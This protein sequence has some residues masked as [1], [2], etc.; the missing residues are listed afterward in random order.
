LIIAAVTRCSSPTE[1]RSEDTIASSLEKWA[2]NNEYKISTP[3]AI[4]AV[5]NARQLGLLRGTNH[6]TAFGLAFAFLGRFVPSLLGPRS[7]FLT[8]VEDRLYLKVYLIGAGALVIKFAKWLLQRGPV[9]NDQL[10]AE[11][12]VERLMSEALDDYLTLATEI[13]DR[14]EIRHERE[15]LS[16]TEYVASTKRHKRYPLL[17]TMQRLH[18]LKQNDDGEDGAVIES[19]AGGR[20]AS[21]SRAL[22]DVKTLERLIRCDKLQETLDI[23]MREF[24]R[25]DLPRREKPM[26]VLVHAYTFAME[27]GMQACSLSFL[28]DVLGSVF[29]TSPSVR[30]PIAEQMLEPIHRE[31]PG[32]IRFHV[33][34]RG[35]RAFVLLSKT[36]IDHLIER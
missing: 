18:L 27:C 11:S 34:R 28:N 21:L 14:T 26:E 2:R 10:R 7:R 17:R 35:Q 5:G 22:P 20:L 31:Q 15:R 24:T 23:E 13:R 6:W 30:R 3:A 36:A 8:S 12:V 19:D 16:H 1:S 32:E 4:Y 29:P 33:N 9:T 25:Q